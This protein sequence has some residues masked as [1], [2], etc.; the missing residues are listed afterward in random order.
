MIE[1]DT[2]RH[3][4]GGNTK[5]LGNSDHVRAWGSDAIRTGYGHAQ[6]QAA[7]ESRPAAIVDLR[8]AYQIATGKME[9]DR[10]S[11]RLS[12]KTGEHALRY[13]PQRVDNME[14]GTTVLSMK[15]CKRASAAYKRVWS[16]RIVYACAKQRPLSLIPFLPQREHMHFI[17]ALHQPFDEPQE[18]GYHARRAASV[19]TSRS[20]NSDFHRVSSP[21]FA[22]RSTIVL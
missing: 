19:D 22:C 13:G 10:N 7:L 12:C 4:F 2:K 9:Q 5:R 14:P 3:A 11:E 21:P 17:P 1:R 18:T 20:D 15:F 6:S 8:Q 16:A